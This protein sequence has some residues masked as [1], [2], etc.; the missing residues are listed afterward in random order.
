MDPG[1]LQREIIT[2]IVQGQ[3]IILCCSCSELNPYT[4]R[5]TAGLKWPGDN[6]RTSVWFEV[7]SVG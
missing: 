2:S 5:K 1:W 6:Y 4:G 3:K 7:C